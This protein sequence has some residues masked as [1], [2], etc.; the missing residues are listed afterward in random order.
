MLS[1][2]T[3][4]VSMVG[5]RLKWREAM[6]DNLNTRKQT[7]LNDNE[8]NLLVGGVDYPTVRGSGGACGGG[9]TVRDP[10][11]SPGDAIAACSHR[12]TALVMDHGERWSAP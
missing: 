6:T 10:A 2:S 1:P 4:R 12:R 8:L 11:H 3:E 7:E 5:F 9:E